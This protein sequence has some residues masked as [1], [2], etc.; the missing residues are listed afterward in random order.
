MLRV[1]SSDSPVSR[2]F[3]RLARMIGHPFETPLVNFEK[4]NSL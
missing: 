1:A 3:F 2:R 4:S